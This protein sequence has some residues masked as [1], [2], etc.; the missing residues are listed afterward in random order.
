MLIH[1]I[2][3]FL[4]SLCVIANFACGEDTQGDGSE[5]SNSPV[6]TS[7]ALS[8]GPFVGEGDPKVEGDILLSIEVVASDEDGDLSK[9]TAN[10]NG[11]LFDLLPQGD[12]DFVYQQGGVLNEIALCDG[13]EAITIR[14]V[15]ALGNVTELKEGAI[16]R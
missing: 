4:L 6:I 12:N 9:V 10:F 16:M 5:T 2:F 13:S 1:R 15:D 3:L 14:A 11:A 7:A 8:C